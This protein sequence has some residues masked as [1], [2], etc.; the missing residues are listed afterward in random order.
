MK[1]FIKHSVHMNKE[2]S[3]LYIYMC[4]YAIESDN[5]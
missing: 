3:R 4:D 2:F 1:G 5:Y